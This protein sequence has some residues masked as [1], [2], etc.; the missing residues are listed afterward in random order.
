MRDVVIGP[1][2]MLSVPDAQELNEPPLAMTPSVLGPAVV[3]DEIEIVT[4]NE[5]PP[6]E[7]TAAEAA[8]TETAPP[9]PELA[10]AVQAD[11]P[12]GAPLP[13]TLGAPTSKPRPAMAKTKPAATHAA[14]KPA[15]KIAAVTKKI[16]KPVRRAVR[17][18][19]KPQESGG[20]PFLFN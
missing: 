20:L 18:A 14:K 16:V 17:P 6:D 2:A 3:A 15:R 10:I 8:P 4:P 7:M 13:R 9:A 12:P 11:E 5:T 1:L 19:A